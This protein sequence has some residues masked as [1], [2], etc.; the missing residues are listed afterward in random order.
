MESSGSSPLP[1]TWPHGNNHFNGHIKN[2]LGVFG[3][4]F[5]DRHFLLD[6][7]LPKK[8]AAPDAYNFRDGDFKRPVWVNPHMPYLLLLPRYNTFYA[9][10]FDYLDVNK[11]NVPV[12][13]LNVVAPGELEHRVRWGLK[14]D[15]I[16]RW[17]HLESFLC[18]T[19]R[20]MIDLYGGRIAEGVYGFLSPISYCYTERNANSRSAAVQIALRSRDA[21]LPLMAQIT[22]MFILLDARNPKHWRDRLQGRTQLHWQWM[23]DLECSAVGDMAIDHLGG[24]IDLT[25]AKKHAD[26][27]LP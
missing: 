18:L 3:G 22:L 17:L 16:D 25:L 27:Y 13:P 15:L 20:V 8:A 10:L 14:K 5:D 21:F 9:P 4:H 2:E 12:E 19:L 26:Y 23:M 7:P 24:N 6:I 1:P 11:H